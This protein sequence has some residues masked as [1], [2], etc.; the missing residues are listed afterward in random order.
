MT[1]PDPSPLVD[2]RSSTTAWQ[3]Q[4]R[5]IAVLPVGATEQHGSHLPVGIDHI[6]AERFASGVARE[7]KAAL[8][9]A[10]PYG[11]SYEHSGFRGTF[12]LRPETF[13]AVIRDLADEL[14]RQNFTR[15]VIINGHGGNFSLGTVVREL[16]RR[17]RPLRVILVNYWE[18]DR[19]PTP[20]VPGGDIHGGLVET[21]KA[22]AWIPELVGPLP[23]PLDGVPGE[24]AAR[25]NDLN[26]LGIGVLRPAGPWGDAGRANAELGRTCLAS[27]HENTVA[28]IRLRLAWFE[29]HP[30]YAGAGPLAVRAMEDCDIPAGLRLCRAANWN[31]TAAE[32]ELFLRAN[33]DACF[34]TVHNGLVVGT[35]TA[36]TY[37]GALSWISMVL[38]D[39]A[40]RRRGIGTLM[41]RTALDALAGVATVKLDATP[42]GKQVYDKLGF[43]D[44]YR[45]SRQATAALAPVAPPA[46][47]ARCRPMRDEDL[48]AVIELDRRAFGLPR[49]ELIRSFRNLAPAC[50]WVAEDGQGGL[51]GFVLGRPGVNAEQV[52]P[53]SAVDG[54]VAQALAAAAFSTLAGRAVLIDAT[55]D[56]PAWLAW[57]ASLGFAEQRPFIRMLRGEAAH[58]GEAALRF[59]VAGPEFG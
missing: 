46:G 11:Q 16:N 54:A 19:T 10:L 9:P 59:A 1:Q 57:L 56:D 28:A 14:E 21:S 51:S 52:G 38:V 5:P 45:L 6:M 27:M 20:A 32:W 48:A 3:K 24:A 34:V 39:P 49:P 17:D 40:Q 15:L 50:A 31:Q 2:A 33:P 44:E 41:L 43:R 12:S 18:Y 23:A 47:A 29:R 4:A 7:L 22:L 53:L 58:S 37:G 8:L 13:M 42:A 26:H 55:L 35:V 30:H 25:Q 36:I